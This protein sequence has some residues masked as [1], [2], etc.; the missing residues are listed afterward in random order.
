MSVLL[1]TSVG[2]LVV[3]L[4]TDRC[5]ITTKNFIKLCQ[6]KYYNNALFI[7]I[8]KD[9]IAKVENPILPA[10]SIYEKMGG[11]DKKYFADE[12]ELERKYNKRGLLGCS[13][14]NPNCNDS[15]FFITLGDDHLEQLDGKH[16]LFGHVAEGIELLDTINELYSDENGRPYANVRIKHTLVLDDP[17]EDE[18]GLE[19]N[20]DSPEMKP[21]VF[22]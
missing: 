20:V 4:F 17:F 11:P 10:T 21:Y 14:E 16:T 9:F 2:D 13:N 7:E 19:L 22:I 15:D 3:D 5:P 6:M 18:E 12:I 8:Q 1:E